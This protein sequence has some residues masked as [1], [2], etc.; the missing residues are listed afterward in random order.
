MG[1]EVIDDDDVAAPECWR[2]TLV[3]IGKEG[4]SGYWPIHYE[5][6]GH[7]V[8]AKPGYEG[9]CLPM[10]LRHAADQ[11]LAAP[12]SAAK[13]MGKVIQIDEARILDH[14]GEMVCGTV[15]ETLNALLDAEADQLC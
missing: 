7:L 6:G 2:Q 13:P 14:L 11:P 4:S 10:P 3:D 5:G 1:R 8:V 12:A 9:D 15:E